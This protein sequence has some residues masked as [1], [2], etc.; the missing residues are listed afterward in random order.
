M[1]ESK[2]VIVDDELQFSLEHA[3][4]ELVNYRDSWRIFRVVSEIVEGY[5]FLQGLKKEVTIMG[6]ARLPSNNKYYRT[7]RK[8][9]K[10]L[11][12][13]GF[14]VITGGGPG[15]M[16]AGNRGAFEGHGRS[17][18]LNI[19]LPFEQR[20]NPY[21]V[22]SIGFYYF[23]T[24]KVMLT[25]P[26]NA[27]F[28][29]PGGFGTFDEFFEVVDY[30]ELGLMDRAPIILIG[31]DFWGPLVKFLRQEVV[32]NLGAVSQEEIDRWH[33][34]ET[35]EDAFEL[36]KNLEERKNACTIDSAS[37]FCQIGT[38]WNI[39]R[40]M[41][42]LV[43]GFEFLTKLTREVTVFATSS[44]KA[45]ELSY[46]SAAYEI[47][48]LLAQRKI[49]TITGGGPG[50]QEVVSKGAHEH[51]GET[52]GFPLLFRND[53]QTFPHLTKNLPFFFPFIRKLILTAPAHGFVC[54]PGGFGTLHHLF[55]VLTL[56][57]THKM[58]RTPVILYGTDFWKPLIDLIEDMANQFKTIAPE[59]IELFKLVDSPLDI[60]VEVEKG[61]KNGVADNHNH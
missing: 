28:F 2:T 18:G 19:Q 43:N 40:I 12:K 52:V 48:T 38:E 24:R 44:S 39:F 22:D 61:F 33:I 34:V 10:M 37:P 9:G 35:A 30:M 54:L 59:D 20:V 4:G 26:A 49:T 53:N 7:A 27:F 46:D 23:F 15:I 6:S 1:P 45:G 8:L 5:Q 36:V 57:Q 11:A 47:G 16:E 42:E 17:L 13:A 31:R 51:G 3:A 41:A 21:V 58:P 14:S 25:A 55:E 56:Q 29:F 32:A 60:M 50:L